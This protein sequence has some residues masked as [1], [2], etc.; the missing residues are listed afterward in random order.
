MENGKMGKWEN[1]NGNGVS[2]T[3]GKRVA[4]KFYSY[5]HFCARFVRKIQEL[6]TEKTWKSSRHK[7]EEYETSKTSKMNKMAN[8]WKYAGIEQGTRP[9]WALLMPSCG[10]GG[11]T[12]FEKHY[13]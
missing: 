13:R 2:L 4:H 9:K 7:V 11:A 12:L 5:K 6:K 10:G 8:L 1:G 3:Y